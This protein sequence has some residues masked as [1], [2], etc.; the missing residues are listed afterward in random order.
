MNWFK[1]YYGKDPKNKYV[2]GFIA[3]F[4]ALGIWEGSYSW[5]WWVLIYFFF[6][7]VFYIFRKTK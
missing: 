2:L 3:V 1:K 4:C 6:I 5:Y 7:A